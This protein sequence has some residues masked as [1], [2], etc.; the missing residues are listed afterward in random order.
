METEINYVFKKGKTKGADD[1]QFNH[2]IDGFE[3]IMIDQFHNPKLQVFLDHSHSNKAQKQGHDRTIDKQIF[4]IVF[5]INGIYFKEN[6]IN[7][8]IP[9]PL[10]DQNKLGS[11]HSSEECKYDQPFIFMMLF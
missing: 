10:I 4:D 11:H 1:R 2:I 8:L 9:I 5:E 6:Q 7:R 3:K